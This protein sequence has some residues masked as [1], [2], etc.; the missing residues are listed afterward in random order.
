MLHVLIANIKRRR[1]AG[2]LFD[3][4]VAV[5]DDLKSIMGRDMRTQLEQT[6]FTPHRHHYHPDTKD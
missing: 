6:S 2:N 1:K 5:V 3:D 4:D